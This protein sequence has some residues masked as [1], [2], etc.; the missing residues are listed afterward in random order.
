MQNSSVRPPF[1]KFNRNP[2]IFLEVRH[3]RTEKGEEMISL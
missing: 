2:S 3:A 1:P